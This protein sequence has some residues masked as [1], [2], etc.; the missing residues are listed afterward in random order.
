MRKWIVPLFHWKKLSER[1]FNMSRDYVIY[2]VNRV[3]KDFEYIFKD[4]INIKYFIDDDLSCGQTF[5][6]RPVHGIDKLDRSEKVIVCDFDKTRKVETLN[7]RG[8]IYGENYFSEKDFFEELDSF[9]VPEDREIIVWGVGNYGRDFLKDNISY[10]ISFCIDSHTYGGECEGFPVYSPDYITD[11]SKYFVIIAI[12]RNSEIVDFLMKKG[13]KEGQDFIRIQKLRGLPSQLL[14][15]TI[16]DQSC[17]DFTCKTMLNHLEILSEGNSRCCCTTFMKI[18]LDNV[19]EQ[20]LEKSWNSDTHRILCLSTENRTYS[21]CDKKMCP[22]FIGKKSNGD[23]VLEEAYEEMAEKPKVIALGYDDT[24]NLKCSTC[25]KDYLVARGDEAKKLLD[26][27]TMITES[28]LD[29][30]QFLIAAGNGEVFL[31]NAYKKVYM[32]E[33]CNDIKCIRLLSNGMLFTP[34]RWSEFKKDKSG[35]VM[36]TVSIDA[37]T[38]ETYAKIR[39]GGNFERLKENMKYASEL[40]KNGEL[41]YFRINFVVQKNNYQEMIAFVKWGLELG[42]DEVFFTKILNWGTYSEEEFKEISMMDEDGV[43]P[44][45][46]LR[47]ILGNPIMKNPIVD[48]GTI[49]Y[50]HD[51]I[52]DIYIENYY[53]WELERKVSHLFHE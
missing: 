13:L 19:L 50:S 3:A 8:Y 25:R 23:I 2:G 7:L 17:F 31:S 20:S 21:F 38:A 11:W 41:S 10:K 18:P 47:D 53:M 16:F 4:K 40:R 27:S 22:F 34:D 37:A 26:Y 35:K 44:K 48:L 12:A 1:V 32:S 36:L 49:Q 6:D 43:T 15:K 30:C 52:D 5:C 14:C 9:R 28:F 46:E 45:K 51:P 39:C 42:V 24:C 33:K 29:N